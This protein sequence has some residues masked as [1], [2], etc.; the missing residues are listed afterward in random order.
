MVSGSAEAIPASGTDAALI[1]IT[2]ER[3]LSW[4]LDAPSPTG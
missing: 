4:G 3:I 1:R 2:P